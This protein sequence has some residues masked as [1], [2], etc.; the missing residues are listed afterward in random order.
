[1]PQ[2]GVRQGLSRR[3]LM[4]RAVF[5]VGGA[6]AVAMLDSCDASKAPFF[7]NAQMARLTRIVDIIIPATDTPGAVGAGVPQ[8]MDSMMTHWAS[9]DT[10]AKFVSVLDDIDA[11]AQTQFHGAFTD[12]KPAQQ[13]DTVRAY[14]QKQISAG[15]DNPYKAFKQLVLLGYYH[16]QIGA[17]QEL[18]YELVPG[19]WIAD[20]PLAQIGRTWA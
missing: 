13:L 11:A 1:M 12:L 6:A 14:D 3:D 17:T 8:F 4:E 10:R 16:S 19:H 5:L 18:H 15:G 9:R 7:S 2:P 20:A